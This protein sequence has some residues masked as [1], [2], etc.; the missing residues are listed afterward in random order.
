MSKDI[1]NNYYH[2]SM[3][4]NLIANLVGRVWS[5]SS[6]YLFIPLYIF[7][8]GEESFAL[9]TFF[10]TL[11]IVLGMLSL[12]LSKTLQR[13]FASG[14][15]SNLIRLYK[16]QIMRSV[17]FLYIGIALLIIFLC[18]FYADFIAIKWLN[19][20]NLD[21]GIVANTIKLMGISIGLQI[22]SSMYYGCLFGLEYQVKANFLQI[23]WSF[24][25]NVG[26]ILIIWLISPDLQTFYL[27]H[28]LIDII[29]LLILRLSVIRLLKSD[30]PLIWSIKK[31]NNLAPLWKF[32]SG[33]LLITFV[34]VLNT[35]FD[36]AIISKYLS[37]IE[38]GAYNTAYSLGYV[39]TVVTSAV[40]A[41]VFP[42]F[43]NYFSSGRYQDLNKL[44]LLINKKVSLCIIVLGSFISLYSYEI[45]LFWT[46]SENIAN[47][48]KESAIFVIIGSMFL[49]LQQIS[50]EFLLSRG[51][52]RVNT[53]MS[54]SILPYILIITP[55]LIKNFGIWGAS[56]SWCILMSCS[57]LLYL[58]YIHYK[59]I[60]NGTSK[61]LVSN[62]VIPFILALFLAY[63]SKLIINMFSYSLIHIVLF[64]IFSGG[65][66]L[67]ILLSLFEK[68]FLYFL[69][70]KA[71]N[72]TG[73]RKI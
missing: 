1:K 47:I 42:R 49:A 67:I 58:T 60:G 9:I 69:I 38:L 53:I 43:S 2:K 23:G 46:G 5:I 19:L 70:N 29:Y 68:Q 51:N 39:I 21:V 64:G 57:T 34:Y 32:S 65:V 33:L 20:E 4:K 12:G 48:T 59:Y 8:L 18:F 3:S 40:S 6:N 22:L 44:F 54:V 15:N 52:T 30:T 27:W 16:Y 45:L 73:S 56:V 10:G 26:V 13:E 11:Q 14:G 28:V 66:T 72:Y 24:T 17:E 36:K 63:L 61:W 31:L 25:K 37:L 7:F 71:K 62:I 35:Q 55:L 41:V 50:Y